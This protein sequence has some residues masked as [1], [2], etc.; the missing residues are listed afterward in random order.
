MALNPLFS[1]G[2][3]TVS[4][5]AA[6]FMGGASQIGQGVNTDFYFPSKGTNTLVL[7]NLPEGGAGFLLDNLMQRSDTMGSWKA[8]IASSFKVNETGNIQF[9][10]LRDSVYSLVFNS[11]EYVRY[12]RYN[13][14]VGEERNIVRLMPAVSP[15]YAV[16][17]SVSIGLESY[18]YLD[19]S[20]PRL[21]TYSGNSTNIYISGCDSAD[22]LLALGS[23][24]DVCRYLDDAKVV[25][26][27][28]SSIDAGNYIVT[29][30]TETTDFPVNT[31][32]DFLNGSGIGGSPYVTLNWRRDF[33]NQVP[34]HWTIFYKWS[35][36]EWQYINHVEGSRLT[37]TVNELSFE[38]EYEFRIRGV[39]VNY[40]GGRWSNVVTVTTPAQEGVAAEVDT[41]SIE[42]DVVCLKKMEDL[43]RQFDLADWASYALLENFCNSGLRNYE[44][45]VAS[46]LAIVDNA[47][48][49]TGVSSSGIEYTYTSTLT[50][51]DAGEEIDQFMIHL[52]P[53]GMDLLDTSPYV[54]TS[55]IATFSGES[56]GYHECL[57]FWSSGLVA[58]IY[59]VG[60]ISGL[61]NNY[62]HFG[63]KV[64]MEAHVDGKTAL[65]SIDR[66]GVYVNPAP[67]EGDVETPV[68]D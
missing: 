14:K 49:F 51:V 66:V 5:P 38:T 12:N 10:D 39:G 52:E 48:T 31:Y 16:I 32:V 46:P 29:L 22:T 65:G 8:Q 55:V 13:I 56:P 1:S 68:F 6:E 36:V 64:I 9:E 35:G 18:N 37:A 63:Y 26:N 40:Q 20:I 53:D 23:A 45:D 21:L 50:A 11:L 19:D 2:I 58:D 4:D 42:A 28:I 62:T 59:E 25:F 34:Q 61:S 60:E 54:N 3:I 15:A 43:K 57:M 7:E 27:D 30:A 44:V 33:T 47:V 41:S 17:T 24:G 67:T